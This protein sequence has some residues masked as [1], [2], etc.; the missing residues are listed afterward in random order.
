MVLFIFYFF[1]VCGFSSK[2]IAQQHSP[3]STDPGGVVL[4]KLAASNQQV[5]RDFFFEVDFQ[6]KQ[7]SL[8]VCREVATKVVQM[9]GAF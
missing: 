4:G 7:P 3:A 8:L 1:R 9:E 2:T 5:L 6:S